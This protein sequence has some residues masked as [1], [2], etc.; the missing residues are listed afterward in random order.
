MKPKI[1]GIEH[2]LY[3]VITTVIAVTTIILA[4]KKLKTD[5]QQT[6]F[7]KCL[8]LIL[9]ITILTNRISQVFCYG[10]TQWHLLIPETFCGMTSLVLS[11]AVLFGKKDN[12]IFHFVWLIALF[13]GI[14][15]TVYANYIPDF[16]TFF[17]ITTIT[18][19]LH[20]T[21]SATLIV[22]L[23]IFKHIHIT[24]KKWY[25]PLLGFT[26][27]FTIGAFLMATFNLEDAF[28]MAKP[29]V[30]NTPLT[31]WFV[32]PIFAVVYTIII[33]TIEFIRKKQKNKSVAK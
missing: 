23:L 9:F 13:G 1:F 10:K 5:K 14:A 27:Y 16:D 21:I 3:L 24:Y 26:C 8:G 7:I 33:F 2:I 30:E 15:A 4:K 17:H 18:G 19:L 12:P 6:I 29:L 32:A 22:A 28:Q 31:A 25:Y 11:L 20:H